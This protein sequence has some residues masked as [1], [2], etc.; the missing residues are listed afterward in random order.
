LRKVVAADFAVLFTF[1]VSMR[2]GNVSAMT[3]FLPP[4]QALAHRR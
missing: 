1:V 4:L 2:V 3:T